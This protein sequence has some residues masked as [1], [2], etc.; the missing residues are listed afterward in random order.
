[1]RMPL[2]RL[3]YF[4]FKHD[5][6]LVGILCLMAGC[7][8]EYNLATQRQERMLYNSDKEESIGDAVAAQV[9]K[10]YTIVADI[11]VNERV[12][13]IFDKIVAVCDRQEFVYQVKVI[14][15]DVMN[16]VSLPGGHVFIFRA[17]VDKADNDDQIASVLAHE[18]GHITARHGMKR[19]E[20]SYGALALQVASVAQGSAR[21]ASGTNLAL[22]SLF[23]EFSQ[24]DE[25][26]ADKLGIKYMKKAGYNPDEMANFFRKLQEAQDKEPIRPHSY[27]RTHPFIP[28]RIAAINAEIKGELEFRDYLNLIE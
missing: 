1:M 2:A 10:K 27:W 20:A 25:F 19:L 22:A 4:L 16:A 23:T 7:T 24:H 26:E 18:I 28:Q 11:S 9:E 14:D 15:E 17:I 3:K 6:T 13:A 5:L 12:Q 8:T 21:V